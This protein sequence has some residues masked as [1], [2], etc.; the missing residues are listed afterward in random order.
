M[1]IANF[2]GDSATGALLVWPCQARFGPACADTGE[3][4]DPLRMAGPTKAD[5]APSSD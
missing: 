2:I 1:V 3:V 5:S 4:A